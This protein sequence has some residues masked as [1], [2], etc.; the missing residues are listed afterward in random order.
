LRRFDNI[1]SLLF[2]ISIVFSSTAKA[3]TVFES[4]DIDPANGDWTKVGTEMSVT[5]EPLGYLK[6][7]VW[8]TAE[9]QRF[10]VPL[11]TTYKQDTE[12]W[13]EFDFRPEVLYEWL[14]GYVGVFNS[15]SDNAS[16]VIACYY[17]RL[18]YSSEQQYQRGQAKTSDGTSKYFATN[19]YVPLTRTGYDCR[20]ML[21]YYVNQAGEGWIDI[22][23]KDLSTE[24]IVSSGSGKVVDAGK[25][26]NFDVFGFANNVGSNA[27][28]FDRFRFDNIYF[29]T[30]KNGDD[31][32]T[33]L[34]KKRPVP[35]WIGDIT[36]PAP[37]PMTWSSAPAAVKPTWIKMTAT[38][39][40]DAEYGVQYFFQ[41]VTDTEHAS[42]WQDSPTW[43]D[44]GLKDNTEYIYQVKARDISPNKNETE[45]SVQ[46]SAITPVE[47]DVNAPSPD[48]ATW[49]SEPVV[50]S[51]NGVTMTASISVDAQDNTP[52][53]YYF[54]NITDPN[55]DSGWQTGTNYIDTELQYDTE[56]SYAVKTRDSSANHNE[57]GW[58]SIVTVSTAQEPPLTAYIRK[59]LLW[60]CPDLGVDVP[61]NVYFKNETTGSEAAPVIVYVMNHGYP[62]IGQEPDTSILQ[63]YIGQNY[64]I[65][66]VDF[67][68]VSNAV[69]PTFDFDL[70]NLQRA[71]YGYN[72]TSLISDVGLMPLENY[73][74]F[75]PAGCRLQ[76]DVVYFELDKHG[77]YGT[78][79]RVLHVWNNTIHDLFGLPL[80]TNPDDMYTPDGS[81]LDYKLSLDIIYPSQP[82]KKL[83]L[84]IYNSTQTMRMRCFRSELDEPQMFGFSMRGYVASIIDHCW[85]PLARHWAYGYFDGGYSLD[86]WNGLKS[87]TAAVRFLRAHADNYGIDP[88]LVCAMG[89]SKGSYGISRLADP[90]HETQGEY[91]TFSGF[92]PGSPEPQPWQGYSSR[93][94][95]CYQAAGNGTRRSD[96]LVHSDQVPT[97][98]AAGRFDQYGFWPIFP[99]Q[100]QIYESRNVNHLAIWMQDIG[101]ILPYLYD[102]WHDR[103]RYEL[104]AEFFDQYMKPYECPAPKVLYTYPINDKTGVTCKSYSQALPDVSLLSADALDYVSFKEPITVHFAPQMDVDS[105]ING[106]IQIVRKSDSTPVTGSWIAFRDN[107]LFKFVPLGYLDSQTTYKI[108][109]TTNVKNQ[110]G[111]SIAQVQ[112]SEFTTGSMIYLNE[113][114]DYCSKW[115]QIVAPGAVYD[116]DENGFIDFLDYTDFANKWMMEF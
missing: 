109:I 61:V 64:I 24:Q 31:Y 62:R 112:T 36:K 43:T 9:A 49:E 74:W 48:P 33:T 21:H 52:V 96:E 63:D 97:I 98:I 11:S 101:H 92:P 56:Y 17:Q 38:T 71:V 65:V 12:F 41:N 100:V 69:S 25:T 20:T 81:P 87:E 4:F 35:S 103:D 80:L 95:C 39:A 76:R 99:N 42:G 72:T 68:G 55:H 106:G 16:N 44:K 54:A 58:S 46:A 66:T 113:L 45:W 115:L 23:I 116:Y 7:Q 84:F 22:T 59:S 15:S 86:D 32:F 26:L 104:V 82:I 57:T 34:G 89:Y 67:A 47:Q 102:P 3:E 105:I 90:N 91:Y 78:K 88:N 19:S 51:Y 111:V 14:R 79:E 28:Y 53:E 40:S 1:F 50:I 94:T 110:A 8:H 18:V 27:S 108:I 114:D 75:V 29:S 2:I 10:T 13:W 5:Y 85:N 6:I 107:T 83:P 37:D 73:C 70:L 30:E 77:S 60:A 93:I